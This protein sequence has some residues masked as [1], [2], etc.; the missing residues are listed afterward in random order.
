MELF[1]QGCRFVWAFL[2]AV[3]QFAII[4]VDFLRSHQLLVYPAA[5][6]LVDT[7]SLQ[8]F[9]MVSATTAKACIAHGAPHQDGGAAHRRLL[10]PF[11]C[12][13]ARSG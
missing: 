1:F 5:N 2:L 13:K 9:A 12:G 8:A 3:V 10:S 4:G 6:R 7:A 11:G